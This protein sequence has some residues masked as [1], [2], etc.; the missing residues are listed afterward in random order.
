M[1]AG[2]EVQKIEGS[3]IASEKGV[4]EAF[5]NALKV[6][7][8]LKMW[9]DFTG[10]DKRVQWAK[11]RVEAEV[12]EKVQDKPRK[13]TPLGRTPRMCGWERPEWTKPQKDLQKHPMK[14]ELDAVSE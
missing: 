2:V 1:A 12:D 7:L 10:A 4:W 13:S 11:S 14:F 3:D 9:E 8:D 5:L 6:K